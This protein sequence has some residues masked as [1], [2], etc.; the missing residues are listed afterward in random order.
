MNKRFYVIAV[1]GL[2]GL[3]LGAG[4][5]LFRNVHH[6]AKR[7]ITSRHA[8][9]AILPASTPALLQTFQLFVTAP[10]PLMR[11]GEITRPLINKRFTLSLS[12]GEARK[13]SQG[14]LPRAALDNLYRQIERQ[15]KDALFR[16]SGGDWQA[17]G[18]TGWQVERQITDTAFLEAAKAQNPQLAVSLRLS[19]PQRSVSALK[20]SGVVAHVAAGTSSFAGSPDFRVH[21]I[22]VGSARLSGLWLK[23]GGVFDFNASLGQITAASG[24][25]PGYI[26]SGGT[27]ALEDGGGVCQISTTLFR[28]AYQAGLPIVE[29]HAHSHQVD[30]YDP[31]GFE[32]TVYAPSKNL[33][34]RNDTAAPMLIQAK[35]DTQKE[36][37]R[38]DFFGGPPDRTVTISAPQISQ[39]RP[40][41][42]P[43]YFAD[44]SLKAGEIK[45]VDLPSSGL[46][47]KI[48]RTVKRE[49]QLTETD[50]LSSNY[51][52]WGGA[53]AVPPGDKRLN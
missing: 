50:V 15:P 47:V 41:S 44:P 17:Q 7:A 27:L 24:F 39:R 22:R 43:T 9:L 16:F 51:Q 28:A 48:V 19:A 42:D 31:P 30:Y 14:K 11:G 8:L 4:G 49:G 26:I 3:G 29:R 35:W 6:A 52:P 53:F 21:N 1:L 33:R 37:L 38:F 5:L 34:F 20:G 12:A 23:Q 36:T 32:A 2:S 45:R 40:A 10:E 25:V 46:R 18:Q 13:A